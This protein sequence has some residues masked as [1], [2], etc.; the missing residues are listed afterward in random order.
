VRFPR[1]EMPRKITS[2]TAKIPDRR[3]RRFGVTDLLQKAVRTF[4]FHQVLAFL[5]RGELRKR[6]IVCT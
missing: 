5:N 2:N 3:E 4:E 1:E 6:R